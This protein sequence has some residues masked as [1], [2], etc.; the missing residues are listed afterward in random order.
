MIPPDPG[1]SPTGAFVVF[2]LNLAL[3]V[4]VYIAPTNLAKVR[5]LQN[6]RTIRRINLWL[7]WTVI[8]W[9]V[10]F[11]LALRPAETPKHSRGLRLIATSRLSF[12]IAGRQCRRFFGLGATRTGDQRTSR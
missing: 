11:G 1:L 3:A 9:C 12:R 8:G 10:A 5:G 6:R 7:G 2:L 4:A